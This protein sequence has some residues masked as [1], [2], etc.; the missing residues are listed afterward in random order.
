MTKYQSNPV[1]NYVDNMNDEMDR[2]CD[3]ARDR[4]TSPF[5]EGR[6]DSEPRLRDKNRFARKTC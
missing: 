3:E 2:L 5:K 6:S 4:D 1:D